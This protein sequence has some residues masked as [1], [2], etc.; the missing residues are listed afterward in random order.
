MGYY[1]REANGL[2]VLLV[3][4]S[5]DGG[6]TPGAVILFAPGSDARANTQTAQ[7]VDSRGL[8]WNGVTWDRM[9]AANALAD[10]NSLTGGNAVGN[11]IFNGTNWDRQRG[12]SLKDTLVQQRD[13]V[14]ITA[15]AAVAHGVTLTIPAG[16]AGI[17]NYLSFLH[18]QSY[19]AA[20]LTGGATP[21]TVTT[22]G[23]LGTPSWRFATAAAI[24]QLFGEVKYEGHAPIKGTAAATAMTIVCPATTN[25]IWTVNAAY[26]QA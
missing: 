1:D 14:G 19:A 4:Q 24:G 15:T 8:L 10:A 16:A 11:W 26:F 6:V 7:L 20:A 5:P 18:I 12:N 21:T 17:F 22:T 9:K 25:V 2:R 13:L 23:I 3:G